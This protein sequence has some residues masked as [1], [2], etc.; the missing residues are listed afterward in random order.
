MESSRRQEELPSS[1]RPRQGKALAIAYLILGIGQVIFGL[2]GSYVGIRGGRNFPL[3][4]GP[5]MVANGIMSVLKYRSLRGS[6]R[7]ST[8]DGAAHPAANPTG[9]R[10]RRLTP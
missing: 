6:D 9:L 2:W 3:V 4:L 1:R 10:P 8:G 5:L 7:R